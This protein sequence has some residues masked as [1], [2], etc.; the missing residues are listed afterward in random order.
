[1]KGLTVISAAVAFMDIETIELLIN[2]RMKEE[3]D[4]KLIRNL[5]FRLLTASVRMGRVDI[6]RHFTK[7]YNIDLNEHDPEIIGPKR[8]IIITAALLDN[9]P[10]IR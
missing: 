8:P 10:L 6:L 4:E 9:F 2:T 1:M 7:L 3:P 5:H